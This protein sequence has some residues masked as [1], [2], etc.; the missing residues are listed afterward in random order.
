[1]GVW[2]LGREDPLEDSMATHSSI[3]AWRIP[4]TVEPGGLQSQ[5]SGLLIGSQRV[6]HDWSDLARTHAKAVKEG[7]KSI[8]P[9]PKLVNLKISS[10]NYTKVN[11]ENANQSIMTEIR[12]V[13]FWEWGWLGGWVGQEGTSRGGGYVHC[14]GGGDGFTRVNVCWNV[15]LHALNICSLFYVNHAFINLLHKTGLQRPYS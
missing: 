3:L 11:R 8:K 7:E 6:R 2:S 12:S 10:R 9:D 14:L 4:W 15:K 5:E 1:M 13:V